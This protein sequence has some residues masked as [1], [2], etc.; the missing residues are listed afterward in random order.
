MSDR[1]KKFKINRIWLAVA[2][3]AF[4]FAIIACVAGIRAGT[5]AGRAAEDPSTAVSGFFEALIAGDYDKLNESVTGVSEFK[6]DC[7]SEEMNAVLAY[8]AL[9]ASY[10]FE[11]EGESSVSGTDAVQ[12]VR[13]RYLDMNA[14]KKDLNAEAKE[15]L[16]EREAEEKNRRDLYDENNEL[17]DSVAEEIFNE[18]FSR[19]LE[20]ADN[21]YKEEI[22][23][24]KAKIVRGHWL[25]APDRRLIKA[26]S[27][28]IAQ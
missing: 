1:Q 5:V 16:A 8:N 27:G 12:N 9:K 20:N 10:E 6:L 13:F 24:V 28:G 22:I 14:L 4:A 3:A 19:L 21:Y 26:V 11:L 15:V 18:A 2:V 17:I 23:P 7:S 25:T